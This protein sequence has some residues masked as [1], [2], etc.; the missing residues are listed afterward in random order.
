[1]DWQIVI[2]LAGLALIRW[3]YVKEIRNTEEKTM[4]LYL[5]GDINPEDGAYILGVPMD[6][7]IE[8]SERWQKETN[9]PVN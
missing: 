4:R 5:R 2:F 8:A 1:M 3:V 9:K 6:D 7:F